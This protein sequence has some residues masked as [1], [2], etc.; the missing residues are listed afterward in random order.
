MKKNFYCLVLSSIFGFIFS[1]PG[2][3][4]SQGPDKGDTAFDNPATGMVAWR[5][6]MN[7]LDSDGKYATD[8]LTSA[9]FTSHYLEVEGFGFS[10]P[11]NATITGITVQVLEHDSGRAISG[12]Q[13]F[14]YLVKNNV[15][16]H[17]SIAGTTIVD[18]DTRHTSGGCSDTWNDSTWIYANINSPDFGVA[19]YARGLFISFSAI[20]KIFIDEIRVSVCYTVP[21]S[22]ETLTQTSYAGNIFPN[23]SHGNVQLNYQGNYLLQIDDLTGKEMYRSKLQGPQNINLSFLSAGVYFMHITSGSTDEVKKLVIEK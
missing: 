23:P 10:I 19:Y 7:A 12:L 11:S 22:T 21:T 15:I 16:Q 13:S 17:D 3:A 2:F 14:V 8:S 20:A 1:T 18:T 6:P 5:N 4:Q 9:K